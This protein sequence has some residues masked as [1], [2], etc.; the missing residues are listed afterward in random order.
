MIT[1]EKLKQQKQKLT[2]QLMM[3]SGALELIENQIKESQADDAKE[4]DNGT[5]KTTTS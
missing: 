5:D 4:N 2:Q 3:I 1:T